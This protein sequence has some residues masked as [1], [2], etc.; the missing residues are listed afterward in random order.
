MEGILKHTKLKNKNGDKYN[1]DKFVNDELLKKYLIVDQDFSV[2][3]EGQIVDIADEIAQRQH[4]LDDGIRDHLSNLKVDDVCNKLIK[5]IDEII[6][7]HEKSLN[8]DCSRD[9]NHIKNCIDLIKILK[10][11]L[12][13]KN[14]NDLDKKD[15]LIRDII[16]YFALDVSG[17]VMN[18]INLE[19][20]NYEFSINWNDIPENMFKNL[21]IDFCGI[22]SIKAT[23]ICKF[24]HINKDEKPIEIMID[25]NNK[26]AILKIS[27][28]RTYQ[29]K[30]KK[31]NGKLNIYSS[32]FKKKIVC[33]SEIGNDF[34]HKIEKYIRNEILVSD[35]LNKFDG[36]ARYIILRLF[37]AYYENPFQMPH[38]MLKRLEKTID[39]NA[40]IY[41]LK[42]RK[43]NKFLNEINFKDDNKDINEEIFSILKLDIGD[44]LI[45]PE[46][47]NKK[48]FLNDIELLKKINETEI[49][50][51]KSE[52]GITGEFIKCILENNY[53]YL[54]TI[55]DYIAGMTDKYARKE[56]K[57]LYL[58]D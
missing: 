20:N 51:L 19:K 41:K 5:I 55:C 23:E 17:T 56:Y 8:E 44:K 53:A 47:F 32:I 52:Y 33:F 57:E 38:Y 58:A 50:K 24:I 30:I 25:L 18:T 6:I 1:I 45:T 46:E 26:K 7:K 36:K 42:L 43:N 11:K 15:T 40:N 4:D 9:K 16:E 14:N 21:I 49:N 10:K 54:S 13:K 31:E 27:D 12:E 48:N 2:T 29:F 34:N 37:K 28:D 39:K 35:H 3:L 22:G